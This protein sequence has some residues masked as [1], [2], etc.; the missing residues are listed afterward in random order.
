MGKHEFSS[1]CCPPRIGSTTLLIGEGQ[2][3]T[4]WV[5]LLA[6]G[7][8]DMENRNKSQFVV[9]FYNVK[10]VFEID[11]YIAVFIRNEGLQSIYI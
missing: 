2:K 7:F 5:D 8:L 1:T 3:D 9:S 11:R 4:S 10:I 6:K